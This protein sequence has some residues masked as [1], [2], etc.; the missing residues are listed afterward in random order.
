[1]NRDLKKKCRFCGRKQNAICKNECYT[2]SKVKFFYSKLSTFLRDVLISFLNKKGFHVTHVSWVEDLTPQSD[3][4]NLISRLKPVS[5]MEP[6]IRIGSGEDGGYLIPDIFRDIRIP[7]CFSPGVGAY[8]DFEIDLFKKFKI[9][10]RLADN[11]IDSLPN[12][13]EF[14]FFTKKHLG[15]VNNDNYMTLN[16]WVKSVASETN[17]ENSI[18][19]MDIDYSE[20]E[21]ILDTQIETFEKFSIMLIEFHRLHDLFLKKSFKFYKPAFEKLLL[22]HKVIHIHPNNNRDVKR[23]GEISIVDTMEFTFIRQ[24][25]INKSESKLNFPHKLD[26]PNNS[27]KKDVV[28]P[29]SW[30]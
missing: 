24:D 7:L 16:Y 4:Q 12:P 8:S 11:S 2:N 14:L 17:I 25:L 13:K 21:V 29:K 1:M 26:L 23:V 18:L 5:I 28:L 22:T 9:P 19:Q 6:L 15:V 27:K 10:S 30:Y 20:Y 3:L